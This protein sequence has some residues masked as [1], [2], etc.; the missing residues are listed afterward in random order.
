MPSTTCTDRAT[1]RPAGGGRAEA[2]GRPDLA[3]QAGLSAGARGASAGSRR[4]G[5]ASAIAVA[6][7]A[8][9][10]EA[11]TFPE[12]CYAR[13][14]SDAHLAEA[15]RQSVVAVTALSEPRQAGEERDRL[16]LRVLFRYE[17]TGGENV[18]AGV[19]YR[20]EV[21]CKEDWEHPR[22]AWMQPGGTLC[23]AECD[24]GRVQLTRRADG[25]IDLRTA[26][27]H[28]VRPGAECEGNSRLASEGRDS[29]TFRLAPAGFDV[30]LQE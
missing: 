3:Y 25:R 9:A 29:A 18:E 24:G 6:V 20:Q 28:V 19:W 23:S 15:P 26:G 21:F 10:A 4:V 22:S 2:G 8:S 16:F 13:V 27:L 7:S 11:D 12:G 1:G 30:C 5:R 17:G 14:Y